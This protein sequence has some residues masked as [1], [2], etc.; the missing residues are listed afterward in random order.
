MLLERTLSASSPN[1]AIMA[2]GVFTQ[3]DEETHF[4]SFLFFYGGV[5]MIM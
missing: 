2:P 4:H 5:Y 1:F 3:Y